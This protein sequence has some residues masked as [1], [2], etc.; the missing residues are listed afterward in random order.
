MARGC[1]GGGVATSTTSGIDSS[2]DRTVRYPI[3]TRLSFIDFRSS[4]G[5]EHRSGPV[6]PSGFRATMRFTIWR[7]R[8]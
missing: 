5:T 2:S 7:N 6:I 3:S 1:H 4:A 8:S